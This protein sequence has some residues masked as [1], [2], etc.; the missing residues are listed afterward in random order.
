[1]KK[2]TA[3]SRRAVIKATLNGLGRGPRK[4]HGNPRPDDADLDVEDVEIDVTEYRSGWREGTGPRASELV[5]LHPVALRELTAAV[6]SAQR[7]SS[8]DVRDLAAAIAASLK[9]HP[10]T[11][12]ELAKAVAMQLEVLPE[13]IEK[14]ALAIYDQLEKNMAALVEQHA[15]QANGKVACS[16]CAEDD[17]RHI[18]PFDD[19]T[20]DEVCVFMGWERSA[21]YG[22]TKR[23][24][25]PPPVSAVT[26]HMYDP[27]CIALLKEHGLVFPQARYDRD[28]HRALLPKVEAERARKKHEFHKKQS[29]RMVREN[30][31]RASTRPTSSRQP[32]KRGTTNSTVRRETTK[33]SR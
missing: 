27:H 22:R 4:P 13:T 32:T 1:M 21:V 6:L 2:Q 12:R 31:R 3:Q 24:Q 15:T 14:L 8:D 18:H 26:P 28:V 29:A 23:G 20:T 11:V 25:M 5:R 33:K 16:V 19:M 30:Q 17:H 10:D 9:F 7:L